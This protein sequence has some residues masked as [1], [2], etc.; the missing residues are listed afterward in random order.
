MGS[1]PLVALGVR[2]QQFEDPIANQQRLTSLQALGQQ[3]Q[4]QAALAPGQLQQQGQQLQLGQQA[5][6]QGQFAVQDREA[7]MKAMQQWDGHDPNQI[8]DLIQKNGGSLNAVLG[9]KKSVIESQQAVMGLNTAQLAQ[10]K[11]KHDYLLGSLQAA[12][13]KSVPDEQLPQSIM[14]AAQKAIQDGYM[15]PDEA[16]QLQQIVQQ[17]PNPADLRSH[18]ALYEKGLQS[19]TEQFSQE[20]ENRKTVAAEQTATSRADTAKTSAERLAAE[21][22]GGALQAPDKAELAAWLTKNPGKDAADFLAYKASLAPN[23]GI[24]AQKGLLANNARDM[25]AENYFQTGQL[26]AGMRSPAMTSS[27]INRAAELH[28]EGTTE[29]AGNRASFEANKKSLDN[30]TGTL[31]TLSAFESSANK[32]MDQF[33]NLAKKLP[34]S[35]VPWLNT[36]IRNLNQNLVGDEWMPAIN[37]AR[38]VMDREIARVTND[39]KLS[40]ALTDTARAEVSGLNPANATLPQILH[41]TQTLRTDMDN[42]H[43]SLAQQKQ[44]IG[45]RLGVKP[46]SVQAGGAPGGGGQPQSG[47][48]AKYTPP[49]GARTATGP[50]GHKI[51]VDGGK[52]VDSTTGAPI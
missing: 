35:G 8:P 30:V 46:G 22:P 38:S 2:P 33:L 36:P 19:Q 25:A 29:L 43:T 4:Q 16:Q 18:L 32:N 23:A 48:P 27:I 49:P 14:N 50:N 17:F 7:G 41:L 28:P 12:T 21:M 45:T 31:D 11:A 20:Q 1:I 44:D 51:N 24:N 40:G 6:Q 52:W 26:P 15:A 47:A 37:A 3:T 10:S 13:D 39:P 5:I 9:A 42:V 34:D